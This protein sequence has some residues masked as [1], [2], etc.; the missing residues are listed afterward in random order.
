LEECCSELG[1]LPD[2]EV[3]EVDFSFETIHVFNLLTE[4]VAPRKS[5]IINCQTSRPD[6]GSA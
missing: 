2:S 4:N 5:A 3:P 6:P 1:A